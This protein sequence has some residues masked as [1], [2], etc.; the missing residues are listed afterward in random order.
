MAEII[1]LVVGLV[2]LSKPLERDAARMRPRNSEVRALLADSSQLATA[3][4]WRPKVNLREGLTR[5]VAWWRDRLVDGQ[6]RDG[7]DLII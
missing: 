5:T 3:A 6:V 7:T 1:D 4:G 2:G